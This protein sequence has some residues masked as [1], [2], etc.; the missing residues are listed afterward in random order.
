MYGAL[1]Y[2]HSH[3]EAMAAAEKRRAEREAMAQERDATLLA[4][5]AHDA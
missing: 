4:E 2:Y 5:L 3:P 1:E